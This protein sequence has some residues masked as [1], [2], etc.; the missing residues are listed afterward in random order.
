MPKTGATL[1]GEDGC[2][3]DLLAGLECVRNQGAG[4][5]SGFRPVRKRLQQGNH[6][7]TIAYSATPSG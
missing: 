7:R 6:E 1:N 5:I 2:G 4:R 3:A